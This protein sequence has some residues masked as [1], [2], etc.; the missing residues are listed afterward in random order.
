MEK[1]R[2]NLLDHW[3]DQL[4]LMEL[5]GEGAEQTLLV[6]TERMDEAMQ[7]ALNYQ[8]SQQFPDQTPQLKLLDKEAYATIQQLIKAG[9][10]SANSDN[11]RTLYQASETGKPKASALS[12]R[13]SEARKHLTQSEHKQKMATV[14]AN[15][16]FAI[17]A[18]SR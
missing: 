17:E 12:K 7:E 18:I 9:I 4:E 13:L 2:D 11:A 16:G 6:V 10:L 3:S 8:I 15:G 14:L 5:H 1:L